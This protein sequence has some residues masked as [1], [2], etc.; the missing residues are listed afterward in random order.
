MSNIIKF[1]EKNDGSGYITED[2][3][4]FH[5]VYVNNLCAYKNNDN[6]YLGIKGDNQVDN[7]I[8]TDVNDLNKFCIMWLALFNPDALKED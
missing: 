3:K 8:L 5:G 7:A 4:F 6:V 2:D 1:P